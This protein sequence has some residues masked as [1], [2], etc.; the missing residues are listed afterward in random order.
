MYVFYNIVK[1][2]VKSVKCDCVDNNSKKKK[3]MDWNVLRSSRNRIWCNNSQKYK[4]K[5]QLLPEEK[6]ET[7]CSALTVK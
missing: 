5:H 1:T 7:S 3:H 4:N 6:K 2:N